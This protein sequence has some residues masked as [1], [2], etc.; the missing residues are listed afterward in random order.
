MGDSTCV[1]QSFSNSSEHSQRQG[2][3]LRALKESVSFGRFMNET[4]EWEK[5]STFNQNRYLEEAQRFS[6]PGLVAQKKAMFEAHFK[7]IAA[8]RAA[9]LLEA[10]NSDAK[11]EAQ[12]HG[13]KNDSVGRPYMDLGS[14]KS[15]FRLSIDAAQRGSHTSSSFDSMQA[16]SL[17]ESQSQEACD[18]EEND[19]T[20]SAHNSQPA[21]YGRADHPSADMAADAPRE[22]EFCNLLDKLCDTSK[23]NYMEVETKSFKK[24]DSS[25]G[26]KTEVNELDQ[27][28]FVDDSAMLF[29]VSQ[30]NIAFQEPTDQAV[31]PSNKQTLNCSKT[32]ASSVRKPAALSHSIP[33]PVALPNKKNNPSRS[34]RSFGSDLLNKKRVMTK[35]LHM[36]MNLDS[37][38]ADSKI[39]QAPKKLD[40]TKYLSNSACLRGSK[41][42][43][44]QVTTAFV[45]QKKQATSSKS[46]ATVRK[47]SSESYVRPAPPP[48]KKDKAI[49]QRGRTYMRNSIDAPPKQLISDTT[50]RRKPTIP[51]SNM[52]RFGRKLNTVFHSKPTPPLDKNENSV[53]QSN[54]TLT[55]SQINVKKSLTNSL[56]MS[57]DLS[58]TVGV[59]LKPAIAQKCGS[60]NFKAPAV[61]TSK[62]GSNRLQVSIPKSLQT[63]TVLQHDD[64][65]T[66]RPKARLDENFTSHEKPI[67]P[68]SPT[69]STPFRFRSDERAAKRKNKLEEENKVEGDNPL[70]RKKEK[71]E[72]D[73]RSLRHSI[74]FPVKPVRGGD[75]KNQH[76]MSHE[77][78]LPPSRPQSPLLLKKPSQG[79]ARETLNYRPPRN[80]RAKKGE[81]H[82]VTQ[83]K[84]QASTASVTLLLRKTTCENASPNIE[85]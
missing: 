41:E 15:N 54:S 46:S 48:V 8:D 55:M 81:L 69:V 4:L 84:N 22:L 30:E 75:D 73:S 2:D 37:G 68:P 29:P 23:C 45:S 64:K 60:L 36:S 33:R 61:K 79:K 11:N 26:L 40:H 51:V 34:M 66:K 76:L 28:D 17:M 43:S 5:W 19:P 32:L 59:V 56:H 85:I 80:P 53:A 57:V 83:N 35:S 10:A 74:N 71:K 65:G 49:T 12:R 82:L 25:D 20:S 16:D 44:G 67:K 7:K 58:S 9:A 50:T 18:L 77:L 31:L 62:D 6:K 39:L 78:K 13:V 14:G 38:L 42:L 27:S 52:P 1:M 63:S 47:S 21:V 72:S 24:F 70:Q 3:P